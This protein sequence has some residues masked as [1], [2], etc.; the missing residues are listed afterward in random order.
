MSKEI[1]SDSDVFIVTH[2]NA[3]NDTV[4]TIAQL[5]HENFKTLAKRHPLLRTLGDEPISAPTNPIPY[6]AAAVSYF[7]AEA[8]FKK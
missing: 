5:M 8:R 6:H 3:A 7:T 2:A 4:A 1:G